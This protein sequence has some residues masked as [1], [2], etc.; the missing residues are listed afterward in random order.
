MPL[1]VIKRAH[2][3]ERHAQQ[4]AVLVPETLG[5]VEV[6][7]G[8]ALMLGVFLFP[9]R[10]FH[11]LKTAANNNLHVGAAQ[12]ARRTAAVHRGVAAAEHDH[13]L[14]NAGDMAKGN[15]CQPVNADMN[16]RCRLL[17]PRQVQFAPAWRAAAHKNGVIALRQQLLHGFHALTAVELHAKVQHV[18][19]LF[20]NHRLGQA[21]ARNLRADKTARLGLAIKHG[22]FV[23][24]R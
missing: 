15:R 12:A 6:D 14:A 5:H 23:T 17:A 20:V 18:A 8:N 1:V 22:H 13:A 19:G 3:L 11:F 24:Q 4:L 7:D 2:H 9:G 10:G 21:K 16:V